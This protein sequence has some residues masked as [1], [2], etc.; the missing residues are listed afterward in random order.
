MTQI[1]A[2]QVSSSTLA[3]LVEISRELN[4]KTD[5]DDLLTH[6]IQQ[7]AAL[8]GA[9]AASILLLDPHTRHLHF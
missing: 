5:I 2:S 1:Q 6:I 7:A 8:T 3:R 4:S 9:E